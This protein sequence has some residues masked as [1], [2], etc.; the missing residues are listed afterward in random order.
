MT[1]KKKLDIDEN[2]INDMELISEAVTEYE[3]KKK[4]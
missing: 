3:R 4:K 2:Q 1:I